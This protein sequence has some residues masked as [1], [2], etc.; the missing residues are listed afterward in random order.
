MKYRLISIELTAAL[1]L[2]LAACSIS[3]SPTPSSEQVSPPSLPSAGLPHET[4]APPTVEETPSPPDKIRDNI[5]VL[6]DIVLEKIAQNYMLIYGFDSYFNA[7]EYTNSKWAFLYFLYGGVYRLNPLNRWEMPEISQYHDARAGVYSLPVEVVDGLI[8]EGK[9]NRVELAEYTAKDGIY[10]IDSLFWD[11][12]P[13]VLRYFDDETW[14]VTLPAKMVDDYIQGKLG[15]YVDISELPEWVEYDE[16]NKTYGFEAFGGDFYYE[17][18][19]GNVAKN[20]DMVEFVCTAELSEDVQEASRPSYKI[21]FKIEF[22]DGEYR[23]LEVRL[24]ENE[25][26]A[27]MLR[28][29]RKRICEEYVCPLYMPIFDYSWNSIAEIKADDLV[30]TCAMNNY[31]E[32]EVDFEG[33]Y[34]EPN[35]P[36]AEV[37]LAIRDHFDVSA[38]YLKTSEYYSAEDDTYRL[39]G[40]FGGGFS[41]VAISAEQTGDI[42]SIGVGIMFQHVARELE[43]G[44]RLTPNGILLPKGTLTLRISGD[45][46][47]YLS[48]VAR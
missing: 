3:L 19:I 45:E 38:D 47:Q 7:D 14:R 29:E 43:E 4:S 32:K 22:I 35:T 27:V 23:Y 40:G 2:A 1:L 9:L 10:T 16:T 18:S 21:A 20:G 48:F 5:Q 30:L 11:V 41:A 17:L 8:S 15:T 36:A 6:D 34:I 12:R 25:N 13:E 44:E 33:V 37:E 28:A 26:G 31:V 24:L 39:L 42:L 46:Y